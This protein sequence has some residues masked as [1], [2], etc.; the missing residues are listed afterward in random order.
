MTMKYIRCLPLNVLVMAAVNKS[1]HFW[2]AQSTTKQT[3]KRQRNMEVYSRR[4]LALQ[5]TRREACALYTLQHL[6]A[7]ESRGGTGVSLVSE[8]GSH[9]PRVME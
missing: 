2:S 9:R 1:R 6:F 3:A 5:A 8:D 4:G 7:G